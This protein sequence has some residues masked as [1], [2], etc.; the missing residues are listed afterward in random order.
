[1]HIFERAQKND[2]GLDLQEGAEIPSPSPKHVHG[3]RVLD[4][5]QAQSPGELQVN[6]DEDQLHGGSLGHYLEIPGFGE[7]RG[8]RPRKGQEQDPCNKI[9]EG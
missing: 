6:S 8:N 3:I 4:E 1:M 9:Q 5:A 2:D 7:V